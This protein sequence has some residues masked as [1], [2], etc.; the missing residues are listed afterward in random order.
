MIRARAGDVTV[1]LSDELETLVRATIERALPGVLDRME[2]DTG[3]LLDHARGDWPVKTGQSRNGLEQHTRV[4]AEITEIS[5]EIRN[6]V[7]YAIYVRPAKWH[8]ATTAWQR[9][10]RGPV[11]SLHAELTRELGPLIV[12]ALR[13]GVRGG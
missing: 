7:P 11:G 9:L 2:R 6:D 1:T 3:E 10:V 13:Q 4:D 5:V 8:G 12:E